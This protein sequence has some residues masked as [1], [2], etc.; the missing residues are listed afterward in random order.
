MAPR[1]RNPAREKV[2]ITAGIATSSATAAATRPSAVR[3]LNN[4]APA[5]GMM[6]FKVNARSFGF[7]DSP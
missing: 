2:R 1:V 5:M 4:S 7:P 6:R 3:E